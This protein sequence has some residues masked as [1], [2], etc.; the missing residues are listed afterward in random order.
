MKLMTAIIVL[1]HEILTLLTVTTKGDKTPALLLRI[2]S[3]NPFF[4]LSFIV[5]IT[6]FSLFL[7]KNLDNCA[8]TTFVL[9]LIRWYKST[10]IFYII[11]ALVQEA[12][13]TKVRGPPKI[14]IPT[15]NSP[16]LFIA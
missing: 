5:F 14:A 13:A 1:Y 7:I 4:I 3:S 9:S 6:S 8:T 12:P 11:V 16:P 2:F 15:P 10:S